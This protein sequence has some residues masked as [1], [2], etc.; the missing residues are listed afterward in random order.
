MTRGLAFDESEIEPLA[1][2]LLLDPLRI[3]GKQFQPDLRIAAFE[4]SQNS[5]QQILCDRR[6]G[7]QAD[8]TAEPFFLLGKGIVQVPV[9]VQNPVG[10]VEQP[11]PM[12]GQ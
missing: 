8:L 6:T 1:G 3:S 11:L 5:R 12:A 10:I 2:D 7:P 9:Q 4:R